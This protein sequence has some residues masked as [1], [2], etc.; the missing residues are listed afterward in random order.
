[1]HPMNRED[2]RREA[3][4]NGIRDDAYS[5]EGGLPSERYVLEP[6]DD[7]WRVFY[8]ERGLRTNERTYRTEDSACQYLL[9][10]LLEDPT[11]RQ[12]T[13]YP[14]PCCGRLVFDEPPGSYSI[15]PVCFWE[16]DGVQLRWPD[17]AGGANKPALIEAQKIYQ[18][19]G[20]CE[21]RV[22][23]F[24]RAP[25]PDEPIEEGWRPIDPERDSFEPIG[26]KEASWPENPTVLYWWRPTFWRRGL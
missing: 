18:R 19:I 21:E 16:D 4:A 20:A 11:T 7:G 12:V 13:T 15:C 10:L 25:A 1:M 3:R 8:S 17:W 23:G 14:C 2:V 5:F 6:T 9:E 26:V 24:V 22:L